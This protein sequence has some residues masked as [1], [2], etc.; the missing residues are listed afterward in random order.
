MDAAVEIFTTP[1]GRFAIDT[2]RDAK[3]AAQ[4]RAGK[5][6][7]E[8]TLEL[9]EAFLTP[10]SVVVDAGAHIGTM[11]IP[12]A[13]HAKTVIAYE[14]DD[15][16]FERLRENASLNAVIIHMRHLGLGAE[17]S[18][19]TLSSTHR[20]NAGAHMLTLGTGPVSV[21]ALDDEI[22]TCGGNIFG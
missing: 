16:S 18:T 21:V 11:A 9:L 19:G 8:N 10:E 3:M 17:A 2:M 5:L 1:K 14:P 6:H 15:H 22:A 7:Q 20:E 4:L 13:R 12:L